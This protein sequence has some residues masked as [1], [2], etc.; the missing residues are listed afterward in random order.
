MGVDSRN[1]QNLLIKYFKD[2]SQVDQKSLLSYAEFLSVRRSS[3]ESSSKA[4]QIPEILPRPID[5]SVPKA[6][7]RLSLSY[8]M[9]QDTELL[10]RCSTLM[11]DHVLKGRAAANVIDELELLFRQSYKDYQKDK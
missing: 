4:D 3:E 7:K 2:L 11:S 10:H 5:E 9:L 1:N 8:P 6:I